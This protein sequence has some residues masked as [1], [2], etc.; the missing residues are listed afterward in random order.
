MNRILSSI[1]A[2]ATLC[3]P[4]AVAQPGPPHPGGPRH[5]DGLAKRLSL[6]EA[7]KEK[8]TALYDTAGKSSETLHAGIR[9]AHEA[10]RTAVRKND[11]VGIDRAALQIGTL[12]AQ[13]MSIQSKADAA[14][15]QS[16]APD[17]QEKLD[18]M[19]TRGPRPGGPPPMMNPNGGLRPQRGRRP[20]PPPAE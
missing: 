5:I 7:Q 13:Q 14:F 16:L 3:I 12:T 8:A 2:A 15:R 4:G 17:Q 20:P 10:L 19:Q 11:T 9:Q 18:A 1:L 6:T